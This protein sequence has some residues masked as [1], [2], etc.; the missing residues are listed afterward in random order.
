M[1]IAPTPANEQER[2]KAV[3]EYH[4]L[5]TL[6]EADF[7]DI[8]R[9]AADLCHTPISLV[10]I[11]D[12]DRQWFKSRY[13]LIT[14]QIS[15]DFAFCSY[16]ISNDDE[17]T[18]IPDLRRDERFFD[19]P[20]VTSDPNILF[21]AG[22]PLVTPAGY[23]IGTL[24]VWDKQ[25]RTLDDNQMRTLKALARQVVSQLELRKKNVQLKQQ[26][27]ILQDA[28]K[29][30]ERFSY[31]ASH[32]IKGPLNNIISLAQLL[33]DEY[34]MK[35]EENGNV[36]V[37]YIFDAAYQCSDLVTGIL[38]YS[39]STQ[40]LVDVQ[41]DIDVAALLEEIGG[42]LKMPPYTTIS[43][44]YQ[45]GFKY[46]HTSR[47]ALKQILM[48]LL[49]NALKYTDKVVTEI[50]VILYEDAAAYY[51]EI[52]DNGPGIAREDKDK[53]FDL[54]QRLGH[55]E[56]GEDGSMGVGLA[57]VKKLTEKLGGEITVT[58]ELGQG[59]SFLVTVPKVAP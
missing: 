54:F 51:F 21:Y 2:L 16:T 5:D 53:M 33:K 17:I 34:G 50:E 11:I 4:I 45:K 23:A 40:I 7:D 49:H 22:I 20:Y 38:H 47:I 59:T 15:R 3:Y 12:A 19:N 10:S 25:P 30:L 41:E 48:N 52:K 32:D 57:I 58:S 56:R 27:A 28:Y 29:D 42:L 44:V 26:H 8:T 31:I 39:K 37:N 9:I 1:K 35:L 6:P 24:C 18:V 36:Y 13:G 46:V 14:P 55:K 43:Y